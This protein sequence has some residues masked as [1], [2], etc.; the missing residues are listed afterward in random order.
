MRTELSMTAL[1]AFLLLTPAYAADVTTPP[2][3]AANKADLQAN[4]PSAPDTAVE[5][6]APA[7]A[8]PAAK[9][10]NDHVSPSAS[11]TSA[12]PNEPILTDEQ[13]KAWVDKIVYSSDDENIGE[14]A[15]IARDS[16]GKVLELHAD[17]GGFLG[18][19]ET[20]IRVM[21]SEFKL[22]ENKVVLNVTAEEAKKLPHLT[23]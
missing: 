17:I 2:A 22:A 10:A 9:A 20:R 14:V 21:P 12:A 19:G 15:S 7:P 13:A 11:V 6:Q 16:K 8:D 23:K 1:T 4:P 3:D 5:K 18:L